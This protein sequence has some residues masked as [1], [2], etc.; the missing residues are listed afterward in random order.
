MAICWRRGRTTAR[1]VLE[2]SL[3]N[4]VR[5][6]RTILTLLTRIAGKGYLD[7]EKVGKTN[8]YTPA[9]EREKALSEEI[10]RFLSDVVGPDA[11]NRDLLRKMIEE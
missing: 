6:Y 2:E 11:E 3:E 10:R 5:D 4:Q 8:Y 7:V 1:E 9:V